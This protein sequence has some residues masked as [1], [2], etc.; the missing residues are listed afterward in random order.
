MEYGLQ[1]LKKIVI[2]DSAVDAVCHGA[3]VYLNGIAELSKGIGVNETVLIETLKGE[4][5]AIGKALLSTKNILK[6]T[7]YNNPVVDTERVLM[8]PGTY[9]RMWKKKGKKK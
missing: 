3:D 8:K 4:A 5:V 2:K 7:E 6:E 1:H 9:P